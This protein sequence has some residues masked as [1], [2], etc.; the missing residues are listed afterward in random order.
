MGQRETLDESAHVFNGVFKSQPEAASM[1][2]NVLSFLTSLSATNLQL[3][4]AAVEDS[5][6][7]SVRYGLSQSNPLERSNCLTFRFRRFRI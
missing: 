7:D 2:C 4:S 1:L 3:K 6:N 5:E